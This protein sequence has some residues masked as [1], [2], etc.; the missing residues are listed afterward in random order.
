MAPAIQHNV[1]VNGIV[2]IVPGMAIALGGSIEGARGRRATV[3]VRFTYPTNQPLR[4]NP[5]EGMFRDV[6]GNVAVV[7]TYDVTTDP[8]SITGLRAVIPYYA[9]NFQPT[10]GQM[11][12]QL[13]TF[14]QIYVDNFLVATSPPTDWT[15]VW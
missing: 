10:G 2:G 4:A 9:M 7:G 15:L 12:K 8:A 5:A 14:V 1:P 6:F 11:R 3:V 13:R